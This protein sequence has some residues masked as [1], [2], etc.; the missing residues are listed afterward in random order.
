MFQGRGICCQILCQFE[1]PIFHCGGAYKKKKKIE[2]SLKRLCFMGKKINIELLPILEVPT[3]SF[4]ELESNPN[5]IPRK[6]NI[7]YLATPLYFETP[8]A[9]PLLFL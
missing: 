5:A 3:F 9:N 4:D 7:S 8:R 2:R 1:P 6:C